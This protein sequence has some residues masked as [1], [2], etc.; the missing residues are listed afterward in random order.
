M[1]QALEYS[2]G[3]S[4]PVKRVA[5]PLGLRTCGT[6]FRMFAG[7][8][9]PECGA[10]PEAAGAIAID[11]SG[12]MVELTEHDVREAAFDRWCEEAAGYGYK[13]GYAFV[14]LKEKF[15]FEAPYEWRLFA[16]ELPSQ[17]T[18]NLVKSWDIAY[19]KSR[20]KHQHTH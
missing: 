18:L 19:R 20:R 2:L 12:Q 17:K 6:C 1:S 4:D 10:V 16:H 9:C 11:G 15:G 3:E 13:D 7:D 5:D 14:K 8:T